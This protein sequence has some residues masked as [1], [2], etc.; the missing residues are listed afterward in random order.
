MKA[1]IKEDPFPNPTIMAFKLINRLLW[2]FFFFFTCPYKRGREIKTCDL[3]F[4]RHG[5]SRLSY[6]LRT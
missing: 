6:I 4:I 3:I 5:S 2:Y 1:K